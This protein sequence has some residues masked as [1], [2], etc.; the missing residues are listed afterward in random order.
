VSCEEHSIIGGLGGAVAEALSARRP[1]PLERVG[2]ADKP[3]ETGAVDVLLEEYGLGVEHIV[4]AA[5]RA[6]GRRGRP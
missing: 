6:I 2:I 4:A 1:A 3:G 5:S